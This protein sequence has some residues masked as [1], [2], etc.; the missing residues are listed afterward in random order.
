MLYAHMRVHLFPLKKNCNFYFSK[1]KITSK[2]KS[3]SCQHL[4]QPKP[5]ETYEEKVDWHQTSKSTKVE[6]DVT[7]KLNEKNLQYFPPYNISLPPFKIFFRPPTLQIPTSHKPV[8]Y[9]NS[10]RGTD[11]LTRPRVSWPNPTPLA[12]RLGS[13]GSLRGGGGGRVVTVVAVGM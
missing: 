11:T 7:K 3:K 1:M 10:C 13:I 8:H 4:E 6:G 5:K 12:H 2:P 9:L